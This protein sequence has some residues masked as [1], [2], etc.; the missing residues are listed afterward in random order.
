MSLS[1]SQYIRGLQCEKA[2]WLY[3]YRPELRKISQQSDMT[4]NTGISVGELAQGLFPDGV[5]IVYDRNDFN[6]MV[7]KT[8]DLMEQG[9]QTI[10]EASFSHNGIFVMCDILHK[11]DD[12]WKMIEVKSATNVKGYYL[13]DIALQWYVL[14]QNNV[15]LSSAHVAIIDSSYSRNGELEVERLFKIVDVTGEVT[16]KQTQVIENLHRLNTIDANLMPEIL[17]G[18][19]CHD[20]FGCD[21]IDHC[22]CDV[23]SVSVFDLYRLNSKKKFES[24]HNGISIENAHERLKLTPTQK[25][26]VESIRDQ[27]TRIDTSKI[28]VF[29]EQL[30]YPLSYFDFETFMDAI[31]RFDNQRP[32]QQMPFQYSLHIESSDGTLEHKEFLADERFDPRRALAL[33]MLEDLPKQGSIIAFN[34]SFEITRIKELA[35]T[36]DDLKE[37]LLSLIPRFI[38]LIDPFRSLAYYHPDFNG[39]FSIKSI[40]PAMFPNDPELSYKSLG[41]QNG[42]MAMET[43]AALMYMEP[44]LRDQ[45]RQELLEYCHLDTLAMVKILGHLKTLI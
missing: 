35:A 45:K 37:A 44:N 5:T 3:K 23:P 18:S 33:K 8:K 31:P 22:W 2:L 13:E 25:M 30:V 9:I 12:Q 7:A 27:Q 43:Y 20:P 40:L 21:F 19:H 6:G 16:P 32:Y 4:M 15:S 11:E 17:I 14:S 29:L 41:I 36:F 28:K 24:W 42:G 26:Q 10:Y 34:Q 1:K 39:S 38:D